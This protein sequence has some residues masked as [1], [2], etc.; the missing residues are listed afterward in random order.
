MNL[1][2]TLS[3][4]RFEWA[5]AKLKELLPRT[6]RKQVIDIGAGNGEM[7][8]PVAQNGG[9][10]VG[11]DLY[12][13][14]A[15]VQRWDVNEPAP[16]GTPE[17][18]VILLLEVVEHLGNP[19]NSFRHIVEHLSPGGYLILTTPNPRW[20]RTRFHL[21]AR[22]ELDCFTQ[23]DL[24]HNHHV[25]PVWP[26]VLERLLHDVGMEVEQ[27]A[28]LDGATPWPRGLGLRTPVRFGFALLNKLVERRD[29]TARGMTYGVVARK[30]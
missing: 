12:P 4:N 9:S 15:E 1:T 16:V 3:A 11:Y 7:K 30:K 23:S 14:S 8:A 24:E 28:T 19:W 10:Y 13:A 21:L 22:G 6:R 25:F 17:A 5:S 29:P 20:S 2:E 26:H 18:D 27:Y